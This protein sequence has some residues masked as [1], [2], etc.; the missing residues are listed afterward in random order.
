MADTLA[1]D[2]ES[3]EHQQQ[4]IEVS[5]ESTGQKRK[6]D[7]ESTDQPAQKQRRVKKQRQK[8]FRDTN[9]LDNVEYVIEN[10]LRKVK[11]YFFE[12]RAYAKG[13]W[14]K[15]E[16]LNVFKEEFQDRDEKY[17]RHAIET[18]L[19][20]INGER[21]PLDYVIMNNDILGHKI[22]RHE[23]IVTAE[24]I[25][26][27]HRDDDLIVIN[28]PG[29]IPV[30]PAGRYRHN[31]VIHVLRKELGV[32]R[33]YPANRLDRPTSG[34]M[35]IGLNSERARQFESQM[36]QGKIQKEYVCRVVGEFPEGEITCDAPIKTISYKL[37][38]N[39]VHQGGKEC[40]TVFERL[41]YNGKTSVVR[42]RPKTGRTHQIRVHLRY[43][44]YPI[45]NDPTYSDDQPWSPLMGYGQTLDDEQADKVVQKVLEASKF[46]EGMW[47]DKETDTIKEEEEKDESKAQK[48]RCKECGLVLTE[49]PKYRELKIWLHA[50]R[51]AGEGWAYETKIPDWAQE[52]FVE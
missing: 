12:Y 39:Y 21:V 47:N 42:C 11:P 49:E 51:Y 35:L 8:D 22:H 27:V 30:H 19:I 41:S 34:L 18:G 13:R 32:P 52:T 31:T 45:A 50:W 5:H 44:G 28:K 25:D 36:V 2:Q 40:K 20:T 33:L 23:P 6:T 3:A 9:D 38:L 24:P 46:P 4:E 7:D 37:S 48:P 14:M 10:G 26:I 17:Y 16:I 29:G 15:R 1:T 43:L